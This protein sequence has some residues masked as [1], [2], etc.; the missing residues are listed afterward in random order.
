M[1]DASLGAA[2]APHDGSSALHP[3]GHRGCL[4]SALWRRGWWPRRRS[5]R[6]S[7]RLLPATVPAETAARVQSVLADLDRIE[8]RLVEL[9][10]P[11]P[12]LVVGPSGVT[13]VD[14]CV[15]SAPRAPEP[16]GPTRVESCA[17]CERAATLVRRLRALVG[18]IPDVGDVP[19]RAVVLRPEATALGGRPDAL[20]DGT[21]V[22]R[23]ADR[24]AHE[25]TRGPV[26]PRA[27]VDEVFAALA[28]EVAGGVP[29]VG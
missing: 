25:L 23:P 8:H 4:R 1:G 14:L 26:L 6:A 5:N 2:G 13:L 15:P 22:V 29:S 21:V 24:L 28:R 18:A 17:R 3:G 20:R 7:R 12:Q 27:T 9:G 16:T 11:W 19:V 10:D